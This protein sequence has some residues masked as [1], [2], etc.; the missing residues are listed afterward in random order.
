VRS[1]KPVIFE[2][3]LISSSLFVREALQNRHLGASA[4]TRELLLHQG[5]FGS[6]SGFS[7]PLWGNYVASA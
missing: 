6:G 4:A 1:I 7:E 2:L 5:S 3:L